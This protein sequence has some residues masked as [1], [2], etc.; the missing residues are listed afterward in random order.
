MIRNVKWAKRDLIVWWSFTHHSQLILSYICHWL[1]LVFILVP[2]FIS[3]AGHGALWIH[4]WQSPAAL[5]FELQISLLH[6]LVRG[7][8]RSWG[9]KT[10]TSCPTFNWTKHTKVASL[11][12]GPHQS[13]LELKG[14]VFVACLIFAVPGLKACVIAGLFHKCY[15]W[16]TSYPLSKYGLQH[17]CRKP[18][19]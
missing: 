5:W 13:W 17:S 16:S 7:L 1:V 15:S 14:G 12:T 8:L 19:L 4:G 2:Y 6:G 11:S 10:Y 9:G 18:A 3:M